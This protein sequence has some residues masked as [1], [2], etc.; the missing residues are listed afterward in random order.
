MAYTNQQ[1]I[2]EAFQAI[3]VVGDGRTPTPIQSAT[4]MRLLNNG[5]LSEQRDGWKLGWY[6]QTTTNLNSTAPLRDE[7]IREVILV[8]ASWI[9]GNYSITIPEAQDPNDDAAL[10]NQI[11]KAFRLLT[12]RSLLFTECDLGELSRSQGGPWGGPNWL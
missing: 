4:G 1:I 2:N 7:D 6:P 5:I 12:K 9:A 11:K 3:G 10:S 8:L